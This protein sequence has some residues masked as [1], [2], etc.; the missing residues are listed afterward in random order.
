MLQKLFVTH[1]EERH[2]LNIELGQVEKCRPPTTTTFHHQLFILFTKS[3]APR[4]VPPRGI[5]PRPLPFRGPG[6]HLILYEVNFL[7]Q[8]WM[9]LLRIAIQYL[10]LQ[11]ERSGFR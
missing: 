3:A 5:S 10:Q 2:D 8:M 1:N 4:K 11:V 7:L 9:T 6:W